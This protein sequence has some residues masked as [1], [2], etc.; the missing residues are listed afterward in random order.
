MNNKIKFAIELPDDFRPSDILNFHR[1]DSQ[2]ISE[3]V[4]K[5]T[6]QKALLWQSRPACLDID[7][8]DHQAHVVLHVDAKNPAIDAGELQNT[9]RRMLA[10]DQDLVGFMMRFGNHPELG[11]LLSR[12]QGLRV[13]ATAT[14][15][16]A[17]AWA[18]TGQ[19]I[20]VSVAVSLRRKLIQLCG[21]AHSSGLICHPDAAQIAGLPVESLRT[22]GFSATKSS[23]LLTL[24]QHVIDGEL[25][26]D[27]WAQ[28]LDADLAEQIRTRL[29]AIK[30]IG[31]WTVNYALL[32]GFGWLD[33]SLH[34]D[35]A[36]RRGLQILLD[37]EE[38]LDEKFTQHW[39][40]QFSPWRALVA[41]HLWVSLAAVAY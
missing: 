38:K 25:P 19:Q 7:F 20:S 18:I 13:P 32:R 3:K 30:G 9:V 21:Q 36:V 22:A 31:P 16:E 39:L 29:L 41:A 27:D 12:Q 10:L 15:F 24:A 1:R 34:G 8:K 28:A 33:G 2:E 6:L 35:V 23:A 5:K 37:Q 17:L 4:G 40:A 14:P 11:A 26:L